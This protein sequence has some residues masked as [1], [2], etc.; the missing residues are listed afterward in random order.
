[1]VLKSRYIRFV[2]AFLILSGVTLSGLIYLYLTLPDQY[3]CEFRTRQVVVVKAATTLTPGT[4]LTLENVHLDSIPERFL[5]PNP[6][7]F[8]NLHR[9]EGRRL[10]IEVEAGAM[11]LDSDFE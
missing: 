10:N 3:S 5:P 7:L 9:F 2:F 8:R 11:I 4:V 1:M 6:V